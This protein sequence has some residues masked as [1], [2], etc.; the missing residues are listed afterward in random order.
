MLKPD[1]VQR[2]LIG[3]I[4]SRIENKG[5]KLVGAKLMTVPT[6][7]AEAHYAEHKGKPFT[8]D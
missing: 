8:M 3:N 4:I 2:N 6:S 1:A 7:L 5:L